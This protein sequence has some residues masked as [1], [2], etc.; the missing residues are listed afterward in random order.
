MRG[1]AFFIAWQVALYLMFA[2]FSWDFWW[3]MGAGSLEAGDRILFVFC[4]AG[5]SLP[6]LS[7][8]ADIENG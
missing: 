7:F 2:F 6:G 1:V 8:A 4:W 3:I 5:L